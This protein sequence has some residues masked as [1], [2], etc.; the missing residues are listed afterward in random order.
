MAMTMLTEKSDLIDV[1]EISD[2]YIDEEEETWKDK[3]RSI[4][5]SVSDILNQN[6]E[7]TFTLGVP[8]NILSNVLDS[9]VKR[10]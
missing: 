6:E 3:K 10:R 1:Q 9:A 5:K 8:E 7:R 4:S 2:D